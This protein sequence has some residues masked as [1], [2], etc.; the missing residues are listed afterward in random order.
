MKANLTVCYQ[1]NAYTH[2]NV[3]FVL[4][5]Q[6]IPSDFDKGYHYVDKVAV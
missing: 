4:A 5:K 3:D 1:T 2:T 6:T